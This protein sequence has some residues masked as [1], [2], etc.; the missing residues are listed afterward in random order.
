L[1]AG[2]YKGRRDQGVAHLETA[3][4]LVRSARERWND[5]NRYSVKDVTN[6][7]LQLECQLLKNIC[8]ISSDLIA[9]L[10][11]GNCDPAS[12]TQVIRRILCQLL[13]IDMTLQCPILTEITAQQIDDDIMRV[14]AVLPSKTVV[15]LVATETRL[16]VVTPNQSQNL[17]ALSDCP[18]G[19][20]ELIARSIAWWRVHHHRLS[21]VMNPA[22]FHQRV[23]APGGLS[24]EL[25]ALINIVNTASD[26]GSTL[27]H[28][29]SQY[30]SLINAEKLTNT[31]MVIKNIVD[32]A[33]PLK[34]IRI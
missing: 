5:L 32:N 20:I 34:S 29:I 19:F 18:N 30:E 9:L 12:T 24:A 11:P 27:T 8:S 4:N 1:R 23:T 28:F 31:G 14:H 25:L 6:H 3:L 2:G 33:A 10:R 7:I 13:N 15:Q 21:V 22:L 26:I 17:S 16:M